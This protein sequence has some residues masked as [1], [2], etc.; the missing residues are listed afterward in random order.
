MPG[1]KYQLKAYKGKSGKWF[2][3]LSHLNGNILWD[4]GQGYATKSGALRAARRLPAI[5][6]AMAIVA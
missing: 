3:R 5:V 6:A 4:G 1:P 2:L